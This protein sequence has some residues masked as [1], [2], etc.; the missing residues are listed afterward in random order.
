MV[1]AEKFDAETRQRS[2][3]GYRSGR[4]ESFSA[5]AATS[6]FIPYKTECA[7]SSASQAVS[8]DGARSFLIVGSFHICRNNW[9][10]TDFGDRSRDTGQTE[11]AKFVESEV[12]DSGWEQSG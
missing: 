5:R 4:S 7:V 1:R 2:Y 11:S 9:S 12:A 6:S 8:S 10:R 3:E